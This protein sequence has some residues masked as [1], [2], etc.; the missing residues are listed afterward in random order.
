MNKRIRMTQ[1]ALRSRAE[2]E[3][4]LGRIRELAIE[5]HRRA[6]ELEQLKK[7]LDGEF[8]GVDQ[9]IAQD[10]EAQQAMLCDWCEANPTEFG[11]KKSLQ[12]THGIVGWRVGNPTLAKKSKATWD[13]MVDIVEVSLGAE[14]IRTKREVDRQRIIADRETIPSESLRECGLSV[15]QTEAFFVE[16]KLD[17][18]ERVQEAA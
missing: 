14:Y 2:A 18:I 3:Q 12:M 11:D 10:L 1:P 15:V 9:K 7:Q 17:Q 5:Q 13:A 16:P 8:A 4:C 6:A